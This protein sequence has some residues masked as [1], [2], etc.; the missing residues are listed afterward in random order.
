MKI[1][2]AAMKGSQE[3]AKPK[4]LQKRKEKYFSTHIKS[5]SFNTGAFFFSRLFF[6]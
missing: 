5:I 4:H 2:C 1:S 3:A 6:Q